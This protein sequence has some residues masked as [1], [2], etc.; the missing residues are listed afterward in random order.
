[1]TGSAR[2][3]LTALFLS[4]A[5]V[6]ACAIHP[7]I[8][9]DAAELVLRLDRLEAENRRLNGQLEEM[10]FQLRRLDEQLKRQQA[11]SDLRFRDLEQGRPGARPAPAVGITPTVQGLGGASAVQTGRAG[12]SDAFDPA[13]TPAA[14]GTPRPLTPGA[15]SSV[16]INAPLDVTRNSRA[17]LSAGLAPPVTPTGDARTDFD[18]ARALIQQGDNEGAE[19]AFRGF[20][21]THAR[22]RRVPD[23]TFWLGET[24]LNRTRYREAAEHYLTVTTRYSKT[25]RAPEAM[26]KLG[27]ALRGLGATQEACGTF[28]QVPVKYPNVSSAIRA[29]VEREKVRAQC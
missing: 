23:A 2:R 17:P 18:A 3:A 10:R 5:V 9:Q 6:M 4:S 22:D 8:A 24:Y 14:P 15:S 1:M 7:A 19:N 16:D 11:D 13:Q 12:R 25:S 29:A 27:I 21:R 26:L 28:E 20:L